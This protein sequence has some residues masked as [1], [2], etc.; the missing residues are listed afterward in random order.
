MPD[1]NGSRTADTECVNGPRA[2]V[3]TY[4]T[5]DVPDYVRALLPVSPSGRHWAIAGV[6]EGATCALMLGLR[7][8]GL[9]PTIGFFSGLTSPTVG[10]IV[11]PGPT[12]AQLFGGSRS[13]YDHH[14]PVW[15]MQHAG[16]PGLAAWL[17]CGSRDRRDMASLAD[18]AAAARQA[19]IA[20][21]TRVAPGSHEWS[22]WR[23]ALAQSMPWLWSR[24][25]S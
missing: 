24:I 5:R 23:A 21:V 22:V 3:E 2:N 6:S 20:T 1:I 9:F 25:G 12:I 7:H 16:Y 14:D 18:V 13:S 19:G 4:L 17:E 11:A 10:R 8:P 15:L